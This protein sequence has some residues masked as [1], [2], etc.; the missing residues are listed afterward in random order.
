MEF[1]IYRNIA[2]RTH[3]RAVQSTPLI[4]PNERRLG[5]VSTPFANP[6]R[7]SNIEM[8]TLQAY[9]IAASQ[10]VFHLLGDRPLDLMANQ[11]NAVVY[12]S[13]AVHH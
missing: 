9:G 6:H 13:F 8:D 5:I 1:A 4:V 2:K 12:N 3:F 10:H 11:M 7:P